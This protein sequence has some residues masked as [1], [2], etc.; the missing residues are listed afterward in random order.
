[1]KSHI[2]DGWLYCFC[3]RWPKVSLRKGTF[4]GMSDSGWMDQELFSKWFSSHFLN[5]TVPGRLLLLL[6][7]GHSSHFTLEL[8]Q[9]AAD[10]D[11]IIICFPPLTTADSQLIDRSVFGPLKS[12]WSQAC[13]D[14]MF[15]NPGLVVTKF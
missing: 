3:Q 13:C 1:M 4:Y 9:T 6:L 15:A 8:V 2:S 11:V 5:Y 14:Y 12:H 7:D 10:R